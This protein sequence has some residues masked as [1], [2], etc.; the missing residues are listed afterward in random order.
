M[1]FMKKVLSIILCFTF[2]FTVLY[3]QTSA[4]TIYEGDFE[5]NVNEIK[6]T[7]VITKYKGN[8]QELSIP[9]T[10]EAYTV[11]GINSF[12]FAHKHNIKKVIIGENIASIGYGAFA[13]CTSLDEIEISNSNAEYSSVDNVIFNKDKTKIIC[14]LSGKTEGKYVVPNTVTELESYAFAFAKNLKDIVLPNGLKVIPND[15]FISCSKLESIV[16]PSCVTEIQDRAFDG[17]DSLNQVYYNGYQ[18]QWNNI[19][20]T[21]NDSKILEKVVICQDADKNY[22]IKLTDKDIQLSYSSKVTFELKLSDNK[23]IKVEGAPKENA[24]GL[25]EVTAKITP[26]KSGTTT[27]SAVAENGFVLCNFNYTVAKCTHPTFHFTKT[28]K[29]STCTENGVEIY[30]CDCCDYSEERTI[31]AI[32]HSL[33]EWEVEVKATKDKE[34]LEVRKCT[35]YNCNYKEEKIIPKL[36]TM[37]EPDNSSDNTSTDFMYGD[38]DRNHKINATDARKVLRYVAGLEE[39]NSTQLKAA[40][41]DGNKKVTATDARRILRHVAGLE[42]L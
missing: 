18:N 7:A 30:A 28:E 38:V 6:G 16:I 33:G 29:A 9:E 27:I 24:S 22:D 1:K 35:N 36:P 3:I 32:G 26:L 10:V 31:K 37:T 5:Y 23:V 17:C 13:N 21:Y 39:L 34:G 2:I 14:Y 42:S 8:E 11:V 15:T 40:N 20:M 12:V 4:K 25:Y 19:N 41:V